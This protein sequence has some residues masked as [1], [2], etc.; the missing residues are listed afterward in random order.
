MNAVGRRVILKK[1]EGKGKK[2]KRKRER[3]LEAANQMK[4]K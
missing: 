2:R 1:R 4:V 3:D